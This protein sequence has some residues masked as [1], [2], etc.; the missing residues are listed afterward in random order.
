VTAPDNETEALRQR[1]S[2][3]EGELEQSRETNRRLNRRCQV[4]ERAANEKLMVRVG[5]NLGRA[6]ANYAAYLYERERDE[7]RAR[8]AELEGVRVAA[9]ALRVAMSARWGRDDW[10]TGEFAAKQAL[11][12]ALDACQAEA[13]KEADG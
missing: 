6:L 2:E 11:F 8:V 5:P 9:E 3:L 7:A 13:G 4:A 10:W 1:V 12:A